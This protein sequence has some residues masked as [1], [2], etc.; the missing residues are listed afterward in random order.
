MLPPLFMLVVSQSWNQTTL[1]S[2]LAESNSFT[3][4][5]TRNIVIGM[6]CY[7]VIVIIF[8]IFSGSLI[9]EYQDLNLLQKPMN[10][11]LSFGCTQHLSVLSQWLSS[12]G[13]AL[14]EGQEGDEGPISMGTALEEGG[15]GGHGR[16]GRWYKSHMYVQVIPSPAPNVLKESP[17]DK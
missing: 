12:M 14:K 16:R 3:P 15:E 7:V 17:E 1:L 6:T 4:T 2:F 10:N 8:S 5:F 13:T 11:S 9:K